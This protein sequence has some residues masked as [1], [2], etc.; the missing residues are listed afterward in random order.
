LSVQHHRSILSA[1]TFWKRNLRKS[2]M[3]RRSTWKVT[4]GRN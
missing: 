4:A 3:T 1:K 2:W